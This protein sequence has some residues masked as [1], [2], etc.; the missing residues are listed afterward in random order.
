LSTASSPAFG[1]GELPAVLQQGLCAGILL[2]GHVRDVHVALMRSLGVP[3]VVLGNH[4]L[5]E[6][7][8][9]VSVDVAGSAA[10]ACRRLGTR[11]GLPIALVVEPFGLDSTRDLLAGY[12]A[13]MRELGQTD[14]LVYT[15]PKDD[16]GA[17]MADILARE[18]TAALTTD[19][20]LPAI[21][22]VLLERGLNA[23]HCPLAVWGAGLD[24]A[25]SEARHIVTFRPA[26]LGERGADM[27]V[28]WVRDGVAPQ[29]ETVNASFNRWE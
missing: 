28:A 21:D 4:L 23:S 20:I 5:R 3:V 7:V 16:P 12:E 25:P 8:P 9:G 1:A 13:A 2:D 22:R 26:S 11:Y 10:E 27:V 17:A 19:G 6:L 24:Q 15:C 29:H 14:H 18:R